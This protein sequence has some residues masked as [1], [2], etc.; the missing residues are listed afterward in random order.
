M[1]HIGKGFLKISNNC[2]HRD[3]YLL[4]NNQSKA[5]NLFYFWI[6][7]P[8]WRAWRLGSIFLKAII[9]C[10]SNFLRVGHD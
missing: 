4:I 6:Q 7:A 9:I 3:I 2:P 10:D 8:S 5:D 1:I